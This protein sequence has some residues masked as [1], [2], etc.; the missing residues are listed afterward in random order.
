MKSLHAMLP[1]MI[2]LVSLSLAF[3]LGTAPVMAKS[4]V[5]VPRECQAVMLER[6]MRDDE[7]AACFDKLMAMLE[8]GDTGRR[9]T[10]RNGASP[11]D[12]KPAAGTKG[13]IGDAGPNGDDGAPG[14]QGPT[15]ATGNTGPAGQ[16]GGTGDEGSQGPVG[17]EGPTG[18]TGDQ[19]PTGPTGPSSAV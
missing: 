10:W 16:P 17:E 11:G 2:G 14:T 18:S 8:S 12:H 5:K 4:M 15:G 6:P 3:G 7:I 1:G 13:V 19:G 9:P